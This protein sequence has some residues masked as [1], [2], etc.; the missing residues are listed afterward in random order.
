MQYQ[1]GK[2]IIATDVAK[3]VGGI[4]QFEIPRWEI[5]NSKRSCASHEGGGRT[6]MFLFRFSAELAM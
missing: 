3:I 6:I 2:S 5:K 1:G 4:N